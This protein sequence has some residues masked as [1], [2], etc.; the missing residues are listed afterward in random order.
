MTKLIR[1]GATL[2]IVAENKLGEQCFA[3]P[4]IADDDLIV[5][6]NQSLIR[7]ASGPSKAE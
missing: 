5:R 1:L 6:T 4:A 7:I 3:S 2:E